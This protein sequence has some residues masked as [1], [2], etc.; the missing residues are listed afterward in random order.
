[1][2]GVGGCMNEMDGA[3]VS[4][5]PVNG[6]TAPAFR[7]RSFHNKIPSTLHRSWL[8]HLDLIFLSIFMRGQ[9]EQ[10]SNNSFCIVSTLASMVM[11][12]KLN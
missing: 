9:L 11:I 2:L 5:T 8:K 7:T 12:I 6:P 4:T 1:M 10:W 3:K